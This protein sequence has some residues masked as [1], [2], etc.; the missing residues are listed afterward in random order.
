MSLTPRQ[1]EEIDELELHFSRG[2]EKRRKYDD[3]IIDQH[4]MEFFERDFESDFFD[5]KEDTVLDPIEKPKVL[6]ARLVSWETQFVDFL[7]TSTLTIK[8]LT[9][10]NKK[11]LIEFTKKSKLFF[12]LQKKIEK[13]NHQF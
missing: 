1:I 3:V 13:L 4:E 5:L 8:K 9:H 10:Q 6:L 11:K 12:R 2:N 7:S